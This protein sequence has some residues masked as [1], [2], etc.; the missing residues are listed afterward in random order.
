MT[1]TY[2][3]IGPARIE[4]TQRGYIVWIKTDK[5]RKAQLTDATEDYDHARAV[6]VSI[7]RG[8]WVGRRK[9]GAIVVRGRRMTVA[10]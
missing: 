4:A 3:L 2:A 1:T 6:A 10:R 9:G 7:D 8:Q 5:R